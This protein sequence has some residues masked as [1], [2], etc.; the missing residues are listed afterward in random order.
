MAMQTDVQSAHVDATGTM[1]SGR[2]R[3]KGYQCISG[4]TAGEIVFVMAGLVA[5]CD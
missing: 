2:N 4:G 5:L 3:L 1:V